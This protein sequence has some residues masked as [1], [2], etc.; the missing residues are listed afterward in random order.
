MD[1]AEVAHALRGYPTKDTPKRRAIILTRLAQGSF[2]TTICRE[3]RLS[4]PDFPSERSVEDW[5]LSDPEFARSIARA[6]EAGAFALTRQAIEI[7]DAGFTDY[8]QT[9]FG[10]QFN[11]ASVAR[12]KLQVETRL[13]VAAILSPRTHGAKLELAENPEQPFTG[14]PLHERSEAELLAAFEA[15]G[16]RRKAK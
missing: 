15:A 1:E 5:L 7:G 8:V 10:I 13:K 9:P 14:K 3:E 6:R 4:D 16:K 2:L 11:M 12:N